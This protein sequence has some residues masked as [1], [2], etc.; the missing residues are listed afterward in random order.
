MEAEL[1][2]MEAEESKAWDKVV[3]ECYEILI[4]APEGSPELAAY[5]LCL[6]E[7]L[8]L[9]N[10]VEMR[11]R[12]ARQKSR[13]ERQF[14]AAL[15]ELLL[16]KNGAPECEKAVEKFAAILSADCCC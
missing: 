3:G 2:A 6:R 1:E 13:R 5:D 9:C 10:P 4:S 12:K 14:A 8:T 11:R 7:S 16:T 15:D